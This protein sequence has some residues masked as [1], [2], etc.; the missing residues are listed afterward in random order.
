MMNFETIDTGIIHDEDLPWTPFAPYSDTVEVK[1][2][3][4][5]PVR[6]ETVTLLRAPMGTVLPMHHHGGTVIVYTIA[7]AWRYSEHDWIATP[8][9]IV[10]ETAG[11][12]HTPITVE[13]HGDATVTLNITTGDLIYFGEDG[14]MAAIEN[15]RTAVDR[16]LAYCAEHGIEPRDVTH[17]G[18]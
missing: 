16:Y 4:A 3:K 11:S 7:G 2:I 13:G 1:L 8:G 9:S 12:R 18:A 14:Q 5:D 6:G 15:W 10:Y 17:F